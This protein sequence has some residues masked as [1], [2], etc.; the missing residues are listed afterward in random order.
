M[1]NNSNQDDNST[2]AQVKDHLVQQPL[3]PNHKH[4]CI[5]HTAQLVPDVTW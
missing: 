4:H 1:P 5:F 3:E 2:E